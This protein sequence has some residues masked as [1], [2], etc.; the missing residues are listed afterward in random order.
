[1]KG[2]L[3]ELRT[4]CASLAGDLRGRRDYGAVLDVEALADIGREAD[5]E[6]AECAQ[7]AYRAPVGGFEFQVFLHCGDNRAGA[8]VLDL[9]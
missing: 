5:K 7:L 1:M 8:Q 3:H 4:F 9:S 2:L 6:R